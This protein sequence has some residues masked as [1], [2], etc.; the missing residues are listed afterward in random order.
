MGRNPDSLNRE[1]RQPIILGLLRRAPKGL[2]SDKVK[3]DL[4]YAYPG[5]NEVAIHCRFSDD[6]ADLRR[7]GLISYPDLR[8]YRLP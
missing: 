7:V 8:P 4:Y 5:E 2:R 3:Q 1:M 6:M